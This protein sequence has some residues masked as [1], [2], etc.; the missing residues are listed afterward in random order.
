MNTQQLLS[1]GE[2]KRALNNNIQQINKINSLSNNIL[3]DIL[4]SKLTKNNTHAQY[5]QHT[6]TKT[7][8]IYNKGDFVL[9]KNT[10]KIANE[11]DLRIY[12]KRQKVFAYVNICK[13]CQT[14]RHLKIY[15]TRL[16]MRF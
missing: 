7:G 2:T 11:N 1:I 12:Q 6:P 3:H 9:I 16:T 4:L 15:R 8:T 5:K 13:G 14:K 10:T